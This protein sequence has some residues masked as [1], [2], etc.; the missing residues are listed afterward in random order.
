MSS[1]VNKLKRPPVEYDDAARPDAWLAVGRRLMASAEFLWGPLQ[2]AIEGFVAT[3]GDRSP[4]QAEEYAELADHFGA[5]FVLAGFAVENYLKARLVADRIASV[6]PFRDGK[7]AM[8]FVTDRQTPRP[9]PRG[10]SRGS[11]PCRARKGGERADAQ[12]STAAGA[13]DRVCALGRSISSA[14][15]KGRGSVRAHDPRQG[16]PRYQDPR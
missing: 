11:R 13:L 5:F 3:Q 15:T 7:E 6:G 10:P 8:D 16:F 1:V 14:S 2:R 4:E 12:E 9:P